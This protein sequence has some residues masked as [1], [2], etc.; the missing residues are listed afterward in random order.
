MAGLLFFEDRA[1]PTLRPFEVLSNTARTLLGTLY[2]PRGRFVVNTSA[3]LADRSA[4]TVIIA[5]K[6]E[7]DGNP[8]LVLNANYSETDVPLPAGVRSSGESV[9]LV[10]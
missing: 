5:R 9:R 3:I 6:L 8:T 2:V 4:Y 10:Q 7:L 1:A